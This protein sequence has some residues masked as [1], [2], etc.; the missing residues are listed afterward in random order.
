MFVIFS[1][2]LFCVITYIIGLVSGPPIGMLEV[3][4]S[5]SKFRFID[6]FAGIGGFHYA[7]AAHGGECVYAS[8]WDVK[9]AALYELNHGLKP[10]G[11]ITMVDVMDIPEHDVLAAGF[12]CQAFSVSGKQLGF[13]DARGTLFFDILRVVKH[14][15]PKVVFLEN[16]RNFANH[17]SGKTLATVR[18]LLEKEGY[19]FHGRLYNA[20]SF[21][22]PQQRQR[23]IMVAVRED[24]IGEGFIFPEPD[25]PTVSLESVMEPSGD[26]P[27]GLFVN[28]KDMVVNVG[29]LWDEPANRLNQIGYVAAGRQG[30]RVYDPKGHA[31]T[32]SAYGGGA[33]AKTGLYYVDGRVRKLT[34]R[35]CA[36]VQGFPESFI[37]PESMQLG[38]KVFGNSVPVNVLDKVVDALA[39]Q[40]ML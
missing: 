1:I 4:L 5:D 6:L 17:D 8:E 14:R 26:V 22:L 29:K 19:V 11:Y 7:L 24:A 12:P 31:V 36:R 10:D 21:G 35:E 39:K 3:S 32:L 27:E 16:V 28:R 30:E 2:A 13:G 18:G 40:G 33:G 23:F 38:W 9:T 20:G 37:L 34:A 15:K 25:N